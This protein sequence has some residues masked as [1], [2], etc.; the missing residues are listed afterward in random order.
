MNDLFSWITGKGKQYVIALLLV[1]LV[2]S[3]C[4]LFSS[5]LDYR[6]V[7]LILLLVVSVIAV[8]FDIYPVLLGAVFSAVIWNYFFI[9]PIYNFH[10]SASGDLVLL[11]MY[12][13]IA[14]INAVLTYKIRRAE[15]KAREKEEK[16]N[17]VKLYNI[18]LNSLSHELRTPI[19]AIIG[20]TDNLQS[21]NNNLTPVHKSQL[22]AEISKAALRLDRQVGNLLD[23]SRL[24]SGFIEAK[25]TWVDIVETIHDIVY[26]IEENGISQQILINISPA[27]P[28]FKTDKVMLEQIVSNIINNAV[29]YTYPETVIKI[30]AT[31]P[32]DPGLLSLPADLNAGKPLLQS[33]LLRLVIEDDG[34]GFPDDE[35][36]FIFD[37]FYRLKNSKAGG[38]GLGLS[39]VKGFA[40]A[41]N[42]HVTIENVVGGGARFI[43]QIPCKTSYLKVTNE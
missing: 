41:L 33:T 4:Y 22:L 19:A 9:P 34:P 36:P 6:V 27:I 25:K 29:L 20:A 23:I 30:S 15:K 13:L 21:A 12:F 43:I 24:E 32:D 11:I 26:K 17:T 38:T 7:A 14:M 10:I 42:G 8:S 2:S 35:L 40:E 37:K 16:A 31:A 28:L 3:V 18:M 39:I 5:Y 1:F